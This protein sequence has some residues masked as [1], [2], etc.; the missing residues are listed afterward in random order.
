MKVVFD[1]S[2]AI[3]NTG[4]SDYT[5]E[6]A[7]HL[8]KTLGNELVMFGSS[9]R[10]GNEFKQLFPNSNLAIVPLPPTL[11]S[12]IWNRLHF[13]PVE[14]LTGKTDIYHSSDWLQAPSRA[15]KIT[16]IHDL[17]PFIFP[18]EMS[19][20]GLSDIVKTHASRMKWVIKECDKIICVSK[21][22]KNDLLKIFP[23]TE[24]RRVVVIPEA[25]PSRFERKPTKEEIRAAKNKYNLGSYLVTIGTIQ[26]RKN[27][28]RL[29]EAFLSFRKKL[30]LPEKLVIIGGHGW[31]SSPIP[32]D[33]AVITTGYLPNSD[34]LSIL[35]GAEAFVYS[36]LYEGFGLPLL[37]AFHHGIPVVTSNVSSLP[38]IAGNAAILVN[39]REEESIAKGIL[40]AIRERPHLVL[41]GKH[42]LSQFSWETTAKE[43]L[44]VYQSI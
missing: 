37:V 43:T 9:L 40:R 11:L 3:Y 1:V 38:E 41:A 4:V 24:E 30:D 13:M 31:G 2:P 16:T 28:V 6:L 15:K 18:E 23:E 17:S 35:G 36:S 33:P 19:S 25:L 27:I 7:S 39:P 29:I 22:T 5:I 12:L 21:A 26:P 10:R 34:L 42:R 44:K 14:L 32:K 8:Q 20:G